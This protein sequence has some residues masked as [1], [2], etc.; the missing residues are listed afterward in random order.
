M[1]LQGISTRDW[2]TIVSTSISILAPFASAAVIKWLSGSFATRDELNGLGKR[3]D[4]EER[5]SEAYTE[6]CKNLDKRTEVLENRCNEE[7]KIQGELLKSYEVQR[8]EIIK[9]KDDY[10]ERNHKLDIR[11]TKLERDGG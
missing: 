2:V 3:V 9:N 11:I 6:G 10:V 4:R 8:K 1:L 5:V 7:D